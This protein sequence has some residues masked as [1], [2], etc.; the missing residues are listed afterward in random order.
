[1]DKKYIDLIEFCNEIDKFHK[2]EKIKKTK[3]PY[4]TYSKVKN[5]LTFDF[6]Q[7]VE[8]FWNIDLFDVKPLPYAKLFPMDYKQMSIYQVSYYLYWR[9]NIRNNKILYADFIYIKLF[10]YE[11][12]VKFD[13]L[14]KTIEYLEK[15]YQTYPY[16]KEQMKVFL[17]NIIKDFYIIHY[18]HI[19]LSYYEILNK[20]DIKEHLS[21]LP[22]SFLKN[23]YDLPL[24]YY[25]LNSSYKVLNSKFYNTKSGKKLLEDCVPL[26]FF[27]INSY[28]EKNN[29]NFKELIFGQFK[30]FPYVPFRE[31]K[32]N[33]LKENS[34]VN[35][36]V[37]E[38]YLCVNNKWFK[39]ERK[40]Y[41]PISNLFGYIIKSTE[42]ELR[43]ITKYKNKITV[44]KNSVINDFLLNKDFLRL[45]NCIDFDNVIKTTIKQYM[46]SNF[47]LKEKTFNSELIN[48]IKD[49]SEEN[50]EKLKVE[51]YK[52]TDF[53]EKETLVRK[54]DE[55]GKTFLDL[56]SNNE[57]TI[58]QLLIE[59]KSI[60]N[61]LH[62]NNIMP[63]IIFENINEKA[64]DFFGDNIIDTIDEPYIYDDYIKDLGG[65]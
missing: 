36:S 38:K 33:F 65:K 58:I 21:N 32:Y 23:N 53:E 14:E 5:N 20:F 3:E 44:S 17:K 11:I 8:L 50:E 26:I 52:E 30:M 42:K 49:V 60:D 48:H 59:N 16:H 7:Q 12:I 6:R 29:C 34:T 13:N 56:L 47:K 45:F 15:F 37:F 31:I 40:N 28:F 25:N 54:N 18:P 46:Y 64:L 51:D 43:E 22:E 39:C 57:K 35:I 27:N 10:I 19:N 41:T 62:I 63:E 1:M 2:N 61:F 9:T 24:K 55:E 4:F